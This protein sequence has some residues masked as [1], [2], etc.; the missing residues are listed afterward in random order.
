MREIVFA[1]EFRGTAGPV[2]GSPTRRRSTSRAPS[3]T[4]TTVLGP[5]GIRTR[6]D[7]VAGE[8][9]PPEARGE[10]AGARPLTGDRPNTH[11]PPSHCSNPSLNKDGSPPDPSPHARQPIAAST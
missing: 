2:E 9:T 10:R 1:L 11:Q 5:D 4:L 7:G 8:P 6:V 3:Q